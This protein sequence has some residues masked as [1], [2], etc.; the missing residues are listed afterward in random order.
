MIST[1]PA[2]EETRFFELL[3]LLCLG[4]LSQSAMR[5]LARASLFAALAALF[6]SAPLASSV[7]TEESEIRGGRYASP[8]GVPAWHPGYPFL[9]GVAPNEASLHVALTAAAKVCWAI[10]EVPDA[11]TGLV[12]RVP[13]ADALVAGTYALDAAYADANAAGSDATS[14]S[15]SNATTRDDRHRAY[16][17]VA[18]HSAAIRRRRDRKIRLTSLKPR[19]AYRVFVSALPFDDESAAPSPLPLAALSLETHPPA[20]DAAKTR[21][22]CRDA[23]GEGARDREAERFQA[24]VEEARETP[25]KSAEIRA[26]EARVNG[27]FAECRVADERD[28]TTFYD[29]GGEDVPRFDNRV[30]LNRDVM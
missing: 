25:L 22:L 6:A 15:Y 27:L 8:D 23:Y 10:V 4:R 3:P 9:A 28:E 16:G 12:V 18:Y 11:S 19:H 5:A 29:G 17:A 7:W 20:F 14:S 13:T 2:A 30:G 1:R 24:W 21:V 26:E